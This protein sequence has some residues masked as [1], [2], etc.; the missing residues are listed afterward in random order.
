MLYVLRPDISDVD[1]LLAEALLSAALHE[2][3][4]IPVALVAPSQL[5]GCTPG[6]EDGVVFFNPLSAEHHADAET[7][8]TSAV[9]AGTVIIPVA[10]RS[11]DREPPAVVSSR[12]SFDVVDHL[13]RRELGEDQLAV[14]GTALAREVL[15]RVM[16]TFIQA[17]VRLFLC[18]R[19]VDGEAL[20]GAI[21]RA[22]SVRHEPTFR[23]L[24]DVQAG[25]RAQERI[26]EALAS[27]DVVVFIDTPKAGESW[28]IDHELATALGRNIPIVWV[29]ADADAVD[30]VELRTPPGAEPH[31]A[32]AGEMIEA[33]EAGS[34]ADEILRIAT[35]LARQHLRTSQQ[36]LHDL[37]AWADANDGTVEPLDAQ[38]RIYRVRHPGGAAARVYPIRPAT[39]IVQI[40]GRAVVDADHHELAAF[41]TAE[42]LGPHE[43]DCRSFDAAFLLDPTA[44]GHRMIGDWHVAEHPVAFLGS[45]TPGP[46]PDV[47]P[48]L[49]LLGAF[50]TGDFAR[51][52]VLPAVQAS[53]ITW[54]RL[55]G[56]IVCGGHPTFVPLL[57]EAARLVHGDRAPETLTVYQS[58]WYAAPAQ[59]DELSQAA[60]VVATEA[61]DDD[62]ASLTIMRT[63][64]IGENPDASVLAIGGRTEESGTH[65]PGIEE[66]IR[67]ARMAGMPVYLFGAPGGQ[68]A[69][70]AAREATGSPPWAGLGNRL[71]PD[72]NELLRETDAY[73]HAVRLI[74]AARI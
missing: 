52:Q 39:D 7:V 48:V 31:L 18:H 70:I 53:A 10:L 43:E 38:R 54:L 25:E 51:D 57:T 71:D 30:R 49:L 13:R 58:R 60:T 69:A 56:R 63:Q 67:L 65:R 72:G 20:T 62:L 3:D 32:I 50:P 9:S 17:R 23:D 28:W 68:A 64:M 59:L 27:A 8:L 40:F 36:A 26:D 35:R 33:S 47:A 46:A 16:P 34:V 41:L 22:L 2:W 44:S 45:L 37:K 11:E 6:P 61:A 42:G 66:E 12:Q 19:R 14:V 15:S 21:D 73:E 4:D 24:I 74:W 55:G 29:R 1:P 5:L